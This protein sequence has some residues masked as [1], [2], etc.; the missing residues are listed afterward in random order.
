[1]AD[2]DNLILSWAIGNSKNFARAKNVKD[3][4]AALRRKL[5]KPFVT[6]EKRM[7][8]DKMSKSQQDEL[9]SIAG[10]ISGAQCSDAW[11]NKRNIL[12]RDLA[13]LDI[14]YA[15]IT[16]PMMVEQGL[17]KISGY[18]FLCH[19]SR[20]HT[21]DKPR[22]RFF[23]PLSRQVDVDEYVPIIRYI[24]WLMDKTMNLVDPV[25]YRPA[26]MMFLPTCSKDDEQHFFFHDN[27][28]EVFDVDEALEAIEA[29]FGDWRDL[30]NLPKSEEEDELRK[31]ADK[32]E[33]PLEKRGPVGDFCRAYTIETAIER[34]LPDTYLP[35][36]AN[37]G[38]PRYTYANSTSSNGAVVYDNGRF[39]YS[40]HGHDPICDMNVNAFDLVRIHKFGDLDEKAKEGAG[41]KDMPSYKAMIEHISDDKEFKKAQA[42]SRYDTMAMFD[43]IPEEDRDPDEPESAESDEDDEDDGDLAA[44]FDELVGGNTEK[45]EKPAKPSA[46]NRPSSALGRRRGK[47]PKDWFPGELDLDQNGAIKPTLHN[48]SVLIQFDPRLYGKIAFNEFSQ[49]IVCTGNIKSSIKTVPNYICRDPFN[50]DRWQD[51]N[52]IT[53]RAILE[54]PNGPEKPGYGLKTSDRDL[55]GG[56]VLAARRNAFHPIKEYLEGLE[57]DGEERVDTLFIRYLGVEDTPF[58]RQTAR[59][60]LLAS[61]T[62]IFEPGHKFDYAAII[63]G[64]QGLGKSSFIKTLYSEEWFGEL[65]CDLDDIQ[66]TAEQIAGNWGM[67][68]PELSSLTKS[69]SQ[70]AKA[71]MRRQT[72]NV[73]MAY[74]R[75]VT[76]FPRQAVFWGT[77][78][79]QVYLKDPSGNRSYW[80]INTT[81]LSIDLAGLAAERNQLWAETYKMYLAMREAQPT[82]TLPLTLDDEAIVEAT[83]RQDDARAL[84]LFE[85]IGERAEIWAD[86]PLPLSELR[87]EYRQIAKTF[88]DENADSESKIIVRRT[89]FRTSDIADLI[90]GAWG[91]GLTNQQVYQQI[92]KALVASPRW[93]RERSKRRLHGVYGSWWVR[94]DA[95]EFGINH[96]YEI[97]EPDDIPDII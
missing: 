44:L 3:S 43:D 73:R 20:R 48:S 93:T 67:E 75:R 69:D 6:P 94:K 95:T 19:S 71:F 28:G 64:A 37:S 18:Q 31:R 97:V 49:Q 61:V 22:L 1:V 52:D 4:Y 91:R 13:T 84:E 50:G 23:I 39:M 76:E 83:R 92:N 42:E 57:W 8:F 17:L 78:N 9:K 51:F 34:F 55:S 26:Q 25:S 63:G 54:S 21:P 62:R 58:H 79:D 80:P 46:E 27:E 2:R 77:T 12:P 16:L 47:P 87:A 33:D 53:I 36:D 60:M 10:W 40:H 38:N 89:A 74:D 72:D 85:E 68:L 45:S 86:E 82:G 56:I 15:D 7:A 11:R 70:V 14:D 88:P 81:V 32:A 24:G 41:P 65:A 30:N 29:R 66:Q 96:G 90:L 35:G 5:K 59:L